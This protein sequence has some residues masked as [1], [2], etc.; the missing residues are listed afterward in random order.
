MSNVNYKRKKYCQGCEKS[1]SKKY[2]RCPK[3]NE[4]LRTKSHASGSLMKIGVHRY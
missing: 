1:V 2:I 3:C 4:I